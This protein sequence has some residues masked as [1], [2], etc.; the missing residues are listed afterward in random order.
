MAQF[1]TWLKADLQRPPQ[2]KSLCGAFFSQDHMGNLVGAEV[3]D[4]GQA[5]SLS[6]T[7][8]GYIVRG[9]GS[10]VVVSGQRA[11]NRAWIELPEAAYAMPGMIQIAIRLREGNERA[12]LAACVATV[13]RTSTD[14][15]VDPG[16]VVPNLDT[17]L[18][19]I[20]EMDAAIAEADTAAAGANAAAGRIGT[21][22]SY[23]AP[24]YENNR[25]YAVGD[26]MA[27]NGKIYRCVQPFG[28]GD[29]FFL[30]ENDDISSSCWEAATVS[31]MIDDTAEEAA[32]AAADALMG[33]M[34]VSATAVTG[35]PTADLSV[36]NGHYNLALG[37]VKG[38]KGDSAGDVYDILPANTVSGPEVSFSDAVDG[39]PVKSLVVQIEPIQEGEGTPSSTNVR[40]LS[41][42]T[43][44]NLRYPKQ[45][46]E[47]MTKD[48]EKLRVYGA[49]KYPVGSQITVG[50]YDGRDLAWDVVDYRDRLDPA[51]G[52]MRPSVTLQLH[53][54]IT[55]YEFDG[56]EALYYVDEAVYP[57][58]MPAGTYHFTCVGREGVTADNGLDFQF[59]LNQVVPAGGQIMLSAPVSSS[60]GNGSIRTYASAAS[61]AVLEKTAVTAGSGGADLGATDGSAANLNRIMWAL[62]SSNNYAK[63]PIRRWINSTGG[64]NAWWSPSHIF[65]HAP[66]N[67]KEPGFL[68]DM[69]SDFLAAVAVTDIACRTN[70]VCEMPGYATNEVYHIREDKFFLPSLNEVGLTTQ[71][72]GEGTVWAIYDGAG[73]VERIKQN[74]NQTSTFWW[75]RSAEADTMNMC[76]TVTTV[77]DQYAVNAIAQYGVSPAC[78]LWMETEDTVNIDFP[79]AAGTVYGGTLDV[80]RGVL[81][82]TK[83]FYSSYPGVT[84]FGKWVSSMNEYSANTIPSM[85]A[86][87]VYELT[88]P[89]VYT[90][91]PREMKTLLVNN[92][93]RANC[94]DV[95]VT[96]CMTIEAFVEKKLAELK[97]ELELE[98][99]EVELNE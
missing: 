76:W 60:L 86:Q 46:V 14:T 34:T 31:D 44:L 57:S 71:D 35:S 33:H 6:G 17:L 90:L 19:K 59:T 25:N 27:Y 9:D 75:L 50:R 12:V 5:V 23:V 93:F 99:I 47:N 15:L 70:S 48:W 49:A 88:E 58:G 43:G 78:V 92:R 77:G 80:G 67:A 18:A 41:G 79:E 97:A 3:T 22:L 61:T 30:D 68:T 40:P 74:K 94:G 1:E 51:T 66:N 8:M 65:A 63:S 7:V 84:L 42:W 39:A 82:V 62:S 4:G 37:L 2:M 45:G 24:A 56:R 81:T 87:V 95:S 52:K 83:G 64:A 98:E 10:T 96:Y 32:A 73:R 16:D 72:L 69:D 21:A 11:G 89:K 38:E 85:G 36:V 26:Y 29:I 53:S 54:V 28:A 20:E 91:T 13:Q 55:S